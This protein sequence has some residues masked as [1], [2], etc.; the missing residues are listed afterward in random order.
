MK[1]LINDEF[2]VLLMSISKDCNAR[3]LKFL[4]HKIYQRY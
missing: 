4:L 3:L 1:N 2:V